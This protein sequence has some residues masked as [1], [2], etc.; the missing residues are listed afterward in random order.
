M[1]EQM[2]SRVALIKK[3]S[4]L[5]LAAPR[6]KA[7]CFP[8]ATLLPC[9]PCHYQHLERVNNPRVARHA[10]GRLSV[11]PA[12]TSCRPCCVQV[13]ASLPPLFAHFLFFIFPVVAERLLLLLILRMCTGTSCQKTSAVN[14]VTNKAT[15]CFPNSWP[16]APGNDR[17]CPGLSEKGHVVCRH[18]RTVRA[19]NT[20]HRRSSTLGSN[21]IKLRARRSQQWCAGQMKINVLI[22]KFLTRDTSPG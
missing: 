20:L 1:W 9:S 13:T 15:N 11:R 14:I 19:I 21:W 5:Q 8:T 2:P 6:G 4:L 12:E 18:W 7:I 10:A 16:F 17:G 22:C 3:K